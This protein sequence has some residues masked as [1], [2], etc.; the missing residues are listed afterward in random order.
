[1]ARLFVLYSFIRPCMHH[2]A[3][4]TRYAETCA[5]SCRSRGSTVA[6]SSRSACLTIM[7]AAF[8]F[9]GC[10]TAFIQCLRCGSGLG[11]CTLTATSALPSCHRAPVHLP[12]FTLWAFPRCHYKSLCRA[13][14][15]VLAYHSVE[16]RLRRRHT[17]QQGPIQVPHLQKAVLLKCA[18]L[19]CVTNTKRPACSLMRSIWAFLSSVIFAL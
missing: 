2:L 6:D 13:I 10:S 14:A 5:T 4:M 12:L 8:S 17:G 18:C 16:R 15:A 9:R 1:M 11:C 7:S 3:K 19:G